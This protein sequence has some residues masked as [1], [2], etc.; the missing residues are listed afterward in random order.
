MSEVCLSS[1]GE[2]GQFTQLQGAEMGVHSTPL[3]L[4]RDRPLQ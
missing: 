1:V 2:V 4:P 3:I